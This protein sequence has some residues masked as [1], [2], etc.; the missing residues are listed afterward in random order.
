[1]KY[2]TRRKNSFGPRTKDYTIREIGLAVG[3][4]SMPEIDLF[5]WPIVAQRSRT[6]LPTLVAGHMG[7]IASEAAATRR[8]RKNG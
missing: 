8:M 5:P 7:G 6:K 2:F 3:S 1:V 4:A